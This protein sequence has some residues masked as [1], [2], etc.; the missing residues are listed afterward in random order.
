MR[1]RKTQ[2]FTLIELLIVIAIIGILAA[3]L[4]PNL[5]NARQAAAE[6]AAQA[7]TS[8]VYTALVAAMAD[9][10]TLDATAVVTDSGTDC[11]AAGTVGRY[12]WVAS[13]AVTS[14]TIAAVGATDF[15]V[16]AVINGKTF[17]N[18]RQQAG[19]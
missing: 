17:R 14:C 10:P 2:G 6:R 13:P 11:E 3:V 8:N 19:S 12:S 1:N 15:T 16:T 5:M 18:G 9:D 7:H 4:I